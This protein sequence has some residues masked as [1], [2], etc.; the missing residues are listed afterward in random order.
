MKQGDVFV[1]DG[2]E[3]LF[4]ADTVTPSG[5]IYARKFDI[6][7]GAYGGLEAFQVSTEFRILF[8]SLDLSGNYTKVRIGNITLKDF[9]LSRQKKPQPSVEM[10]NSMDELE[11]RMRPH[12]YSDVGFLGVTESLESVLSQDEQTFK[13]LGITFEKV[14]GELQRIIGATREQKRK[15]KSPESR[16]HERASFD[17]YQKAVKQTLPPIFTHENL[18][19]LDIGNLFDKYQVFFMEFRGGQE[20]PWDCNTYESGVHRI[21]LQ[22]QK[23]DDKVPLWSSF[24]FLLINRQTGEYIFAPGLIVH[25]IMEHHFFE[26]KE[27]PYRVEPS[28][29]VQVLGLV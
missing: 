3:P 14:G 29:L 27:S 21:G 4:I 19:D 10:S 24:D 22:P 15:L 5:A 20:C 11:K 28:K 13:N 23:S 18:P 26:G 17:W 7:K 16:E 8:N 1:I 9:V 12:A 25:L 6:H 2:I